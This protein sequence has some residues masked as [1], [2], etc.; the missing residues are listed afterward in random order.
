MLKR[1][2]VTSLEKFRRFMTEASS[3]DT[4][5]ALIET[6]KGEFKGNDKTRIGGAFHKIIEE[7]I[8]T[9]TW[10]NDQPGY[11][12]DDIFF[13]LEQGDV[14]LIY[15]NDHPLMVN[16]V[17]I[18]KIYK[19]S[20][21]EIMITGRIDSIEGVELRD[22]KTKFRSP[23]FQ[24]YLDSCQW[25]YYL[26]VLSLDVLWYDI[27]EIRGFKALGE[28]T[29]YLLPD[30]KIVPHE[31][32]KCTRYLNLHADCQHLLQEFMDYIDARGFHNLLKP[33]VIEPSIF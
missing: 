30:I 18:N 28:V 16:E 8:K 14:A 2:S 19:T 12:V 1:I 24:E 15:R 11:L 29:P 25:K 27:F 23:D 21:G 3:F 7:N 17:S 5:E 4:E 20:Y 26:D 13:S 6:I 33:A 9:P 22:A 31:P 32:L 10:V